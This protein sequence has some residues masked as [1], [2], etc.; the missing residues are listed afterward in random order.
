MGKNV[1]NSVI[2]TGG[3]IVLRKQNQ[4]LLKE[5]GKRVYLKVPQEELQQRLK[6]DR[7]RPLLKKKETKTVVQN[8]MK[9]RGLL[10]EQAEYIVDAGLRSPNQI[11]SE[12]INKLCNGNHDH[13]F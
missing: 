13:N 2:A 9:E 11:V 1:E 4:R 8:M 10:Y 3:G 12:I 6:N 5:I 7:N